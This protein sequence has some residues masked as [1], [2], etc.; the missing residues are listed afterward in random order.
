TPIFST[1]EKVIGSFA[2][3]YDRPRSPSPRD[4]DM[5]GQIT[6]LAGIAIERKLTQDRLSLSER[7]LAEAQHLTQ[8]GSFVWDVKSNKAL[9]LSDE[10]YRIYGF[11]IGEPDAWEERLK[12]L[13]PQDARA[14]GEAGDR[15]IRDK[16]DYESEKGV[17]VLD[18]TTRYLHAIGHPVLNSS[19]EV[20][21]FMGTVTDITER[22]H[23]EQELRAS[24]ARFRTFVDHAT[25]AF[26]LF[27]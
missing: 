26:M 25:D 11:D 12:R 15:A 13:P 8:T 10:W 4:Q 2:M 17:V 5:I 24:E 6:H 7:N 19:A 20:I 18:G 21:Q 27:G 3:Y 23:S 1:Q 9:Y 14:W 22:K 16:A